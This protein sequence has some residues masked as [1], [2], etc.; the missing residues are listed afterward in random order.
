MA[1]EIAATAI[2]L[3]VSLVSDNRLF[4]GGS[5]LRLITADAAR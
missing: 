1:T 4:N 2:R 5:G 3:Y